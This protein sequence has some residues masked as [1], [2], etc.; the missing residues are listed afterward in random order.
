MIAK[1]NVF[2]ACGCSANLTIHDDN[3][4]EAV[5]RY[6]TIKCP[7]C[8]EKQDHIAIAMSEHLADDTGEHDPFC[9]C[10]ECYDKPVHDIMCGCPECLAAFG[11]LEVVGN[12]ADARKWQEEAMEAMGEPIDFTCESQC[13]T[14]GFES[15][16][17]GNAL[18]GEYH[19]D[20]C[21]K[22]THG[23]GA[24]SFIA[25]PNCSGTGKTGHV[26]P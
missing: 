1:L 21:G 25:C 24:A 26:Y 9:A 20:I 5:K 3:L 15:N 19:C 8:R 16:Y 17:G 2:F 6:S 14:D 12:P 7:S 23:D 22:L 13:E 4:N 11:E 18:E 10:D